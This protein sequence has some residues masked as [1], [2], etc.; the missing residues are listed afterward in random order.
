MIFSA[1]LWVEYGQMQHDT[2]R[3]RQAHA[4]R[5]IDDELYQRFA[6]GEFDR[7]WDS[8]PAKKNPAQ[9]DPE[10]DRLAHATRGI[11]DDM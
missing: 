8:R 5:G 7:Q 10:R 4:M 3:D 2:E 6:R 9:L 11:D 1:G